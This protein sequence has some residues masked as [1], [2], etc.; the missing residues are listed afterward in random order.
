MKNHITAVS[1]WLVVVPIL[2]M[3]TLLASPASGQVTNAEITITSV[4]TDPPGP[5][6]ASD[7]VTGIVTGVDPAQYKVVIYAFGDKWY[8]QPTVAS[9]LTDIGSD[10]K[11]ES[12]SH[13]GTKFV[14]LLVKPSYQ[15]DANPDEI[16]SVGG[17]VVAKSKAVKPAKQ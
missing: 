17:D 10:G 16:A 11:W 6:M 2:F 3:M 9:P 15:P 4:P 1:C 14:A 12:Q 13:G 8:V 7:P 5:D